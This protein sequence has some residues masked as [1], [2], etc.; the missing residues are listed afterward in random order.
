MKEVQW[1][2]NEMQE[3]AK[4]SVTSANVNSNSLIDFIGYILTKYKNEKV[5]PTAQDTQD[6]DRRGVTQ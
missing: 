5:N 2:L 4:K 1:L 3:F 6:Y